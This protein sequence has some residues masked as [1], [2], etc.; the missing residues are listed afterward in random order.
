MARRFRHHVRTRWNPH[1]RIW[2]EA[3]AFCPSDEA[4]AH[5]V[6]YSRPFVV[7]WVC[8]ACHRL[9]EQGELKVTA[10][11]LWDYTSLVRTRPG[12]WRTGEPDRRSRRRVAGND[13][14]NGAPF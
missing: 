14:G 4:Q 2:R 7:A 13:A 11:H 6:D 9:V 12:G 10:R 5:H 3:C 8:E 1:G